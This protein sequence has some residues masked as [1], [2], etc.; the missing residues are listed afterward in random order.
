MINRAGARSNQTDYRPNNLD[1][2][3]LTIDYLQ[4]LVTIFQNKFIVARIPVFSCVSVP[5]DF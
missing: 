3:V 2:S 1:S 4:Q 5:C